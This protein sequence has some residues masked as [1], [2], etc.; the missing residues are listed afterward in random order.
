[1]K[2]TTPNISFDFRETAKGVNALQNSIT[3][4]VMRQMKA[5][6]LKVRVYRDRRAMGQAAALAAADAIRSVLVEKDTVNIVFAAAQS[7]T[8]FLEA[9]CGMPGVDWS[10]IVALHMDDYI[11][12]PIDAPQGF[13][14][15]LKTRVFDTV[16]PGKVFYMRKEGKTAEQ[17]CERYGKLLGQ[18][19]I[20]ITCLGIGENG[21]IAFN[22][23]PV[24]DFADPVPVKIVTLDERCRQ[25]QVNDGEF[26]SLASVPAQAIT[27]TVSALMAS[28]RI[29]GIVPGTR[30]SEAVYRTI[31]GAIE[32]A[33]P[34]SVLRCHDNACL[35][36]D[37]ESASLLQ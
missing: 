16:R 7:Q 33:C 24:A 10:R 14:L 36:L 1:M 32:T 2:L 5:D 31:T 4:Q 8:E 29:I 28:R 6:Q 21:H 12:L 15:W 3:P 35:Y 30:K 9:L 26:A 20:D 37:E 34:A 22:D 23:P 27:L 18:Y 19:P 13:G 17:I 25:Q 11:D